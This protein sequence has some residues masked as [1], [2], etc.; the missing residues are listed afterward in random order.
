MAVDY[1]EILGTPTQWGASFIVLGVAA[2]TQLAGK[3]SLSPESQ[4]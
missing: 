2:I 4:R 1:G 3:I